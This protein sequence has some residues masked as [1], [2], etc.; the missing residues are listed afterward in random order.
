MSDAVHRLRERL[1]TLYDLKSID[2]LLGWDRETMLPPEGVAYRADQAATLARLIHAQETDDAWGSLLAEAERETARRPYDSDEASLVRVARRRYERARRLPEALVVEASRVA[3]AAVPAWQKAR[4]TADFA[5]FAPHLA[6]TVALQREQA[7]AL[8]YAADPYDALLDGFEEGLTAA[9]VDEL[10]A[11]LGAGLAPLVAQIARR[12][13]AVDASVLAQPWPVQA[14]WDFGLAALG[15]IGFDLGRGRQDASAHPFT[16]ALDPTDVRLTTRL[17]P[18]HLSPALF[19]TLH[20]GGHGIYE[21]GV[22]KA[23]GR[24]PLGQLA[25]LSAHE[26]QSRLYE[27][28]V[29]RS[30]PFW[31]H[32]YPKLQ[33][34]FPEQL[35]GVDPEAFY[36]AINRVEPSCI[37]VEADEVTYNLHIFLRYELERELISGRLAVESLPAAWNARM[38][39]TLGVTPPDDA[40]GVLQDIHWADGLFGYFPT[41][42]LGNVLSCQLFARVR[43]EHPDLDAQ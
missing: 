18:D 35:R 30:R 28:L 13:D 4:A 7:D 16:Q 15:A 25:S 11:R 19:A 27:N 22:P 37:R 40:Q 17:D 1:H 23:F 31:R 41:Y 34:G 6:R 14:Q 12:L 2:F 8:G 32:F 24:T 21:Q 29:G 20:E 10:F 39:R 36:R 5:L 42:A 38:Q 43:A 26:S 3:S 33:A 9:E